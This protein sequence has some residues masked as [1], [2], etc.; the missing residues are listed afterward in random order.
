LT[1]LVKR[2]RCWLLGAAA[3]GQPA[4][5]TPPMRTLR[6]TSPACKQGH[7]KDLQNDAQ[8]SPEQSVR[9]TQ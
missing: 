8:V 4:S 9:N 5:I 2:T 7:D 6:N 1:L 3:L